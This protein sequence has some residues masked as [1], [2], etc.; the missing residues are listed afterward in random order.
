[1]RC[2]FERMK[3]PAVFLAV[4]LA[5]QSLMPLVPTWGVFL[6]HGHIATGRVTERDW[7][8]HGENHRTP[9]PQDTAHAETKLLSVAANDGLSSLFGSMAIGEPQSLIIENTADDIFGDCV[10]VCPNALEICLPVLVPPPII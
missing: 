2:W 1:M 9:P 5:V 8:A 10:H 6:P 3:F 4:W 7:Q